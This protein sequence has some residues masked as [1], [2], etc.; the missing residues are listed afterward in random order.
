MSKNKKQVRVATYRRTRFPG[1][2]LRL[3]VV[4]GWPRLAAAG[5]DGAC[6][7]C[8]DETWPVSFRDKHK[9]SGAC[10]PL[11]GAE[12]CIQVAPLIM[13]A[14]GL[15][16]CASPCLPACRSW[17][18]WWQPGWSM[19]TL[20]RAQSRAGSGSG[21]RAASF[22]FPHHW[23]IKGIPVYEKKK[24]KKI[25]CLSYVSFFRLTFYACGVSSAFKHETSLHPLG[26]LNTRHDIIFIYL[27]P[28][29]LS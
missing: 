28:C 4:L 27:F 21:G 26:V 5:D 23:T 25:V 10:Q 13:S 24:E 22:T 9:N 2:F 7:G 20:P 19:E 6:P 1:C 29:H 8:T 17:A 3:T 18:E 11:I 16:G 12:E 15:W 14:A